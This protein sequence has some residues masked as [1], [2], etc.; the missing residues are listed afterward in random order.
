LESAYLVPPLS[1]L[2]ESLIK[3]GKD[4][5]FTHDGAAPTPA[6]ERLAI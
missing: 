4:R 1:Q 2:G 3:A 6:G 5:M